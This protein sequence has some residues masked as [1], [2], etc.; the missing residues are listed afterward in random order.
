[1]K[2]NRVTGVLLARN[3]HT[4]K[5]ADLSTGDNLSD[6]EVQRLLDL[7]LDLLDREGTPAAFAARPDGEV[8]ED[9]RERM[10]RVARD[11]LATRPQLEEAFR[12]IE[13]RIVTLINVIR[14]YG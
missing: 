9:G 1:M 14:G 11:L 13:K 12:Q 6:A 7:L 4:A 3:G 5:S 2:R 10:L 8:K